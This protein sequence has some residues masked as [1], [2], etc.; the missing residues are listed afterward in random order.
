LELDAQ[1]LVVEIASNDGYLLIPFQRRGTRVLGVEPAANVAAIALDHGIP[2][3]S[4]FFGVELAERLVAEHGH[5]KLV[6][7]N[8]VLAHVPDLQDFV[9]GL[10]AL[11]GPETVITVENPSFLTLLVHGLF[12]TIYHEHFS[13]L[14]AH[15][16]QAVAE[17]HGLDLFDVEEL[18]THGGSNRYFLCRA[19]E[20]PTGARVAHLLDVERSSGL[21]DAAL[22]RRFAAG[23]HETIEG[24]RSWL[25]E[26]RSMGASVCGYGAAA[27]GNTLLNAAGATRTDLVA[28][29]D[30][31]KEK[32]GRYLPGT[33]IPVIA[34]PALSALRPDVILV[35]PWNLER[36]LLPLLADLVPGCPVWVGVPSMRKSSGAR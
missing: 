29:A 14:T 4:E 26:Q 24:L 34:P 33:D 20:R 23:A 3:I 36:E 6:V 8:N 10:S 25:D 2:T 15:S 18:A 27:K 13:Y 21:F 35:L 7:A 12:D 31:S 11:A 22:H 16:V 5:P 9:G 17:R 1:D 28:V 30:A 19:G 32:Q